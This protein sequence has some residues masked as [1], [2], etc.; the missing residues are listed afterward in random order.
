MIK[1]IPFKVILIVM[2]GFIV[3]FWITTGCTPWGDQSK[4]VNKNNAII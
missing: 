3:L 4:C 2:G 1:L